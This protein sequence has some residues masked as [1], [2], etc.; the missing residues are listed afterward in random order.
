MYR[1][2]DTHWE[3]GRRFIWYMQ[4]HWWCPKL[5][6]G[7]WVAALPSRLNFLLQPQHRFVASG[8]HN[9]DRGPDRSR[10]LMIGSGFWKHHE[11]RFIGNCRIFSDHILLLN[12]PTPKYYVTGGFPKSG[13]CSS[14]FVAAEAQFLEVSFWMRPNPLK[15]RFDGPDVPFCIKKFKETW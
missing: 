4:G 13:I 11:G 14:P 9:P 5:P 15:R 1:W 6:T 8:D 3:L 7:S 10:I 12:C 2:F